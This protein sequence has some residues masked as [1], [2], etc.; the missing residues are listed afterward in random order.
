MLDFKTKRILIILLVLT[1]FLVT[2]GC[3]K[4]DPAVDQQ[5]LMQELQNLKAEN[6]SLKEQ[7]RLSEMDAMG[8]DAQSDMELYPQIS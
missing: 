7:L 6:S 4:D 8:L 5:N 3:K 2:V 1:V